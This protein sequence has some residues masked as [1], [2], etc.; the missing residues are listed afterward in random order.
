MLFGTP[1]VTLPTD[2]IKS[3]LVLG[4]YKQMEITNPPVAKNIKD[5]VDLAVHYANRDDIDKLKKIY[6]EAAEKKLFNTKKAGDEFNKILLDL[7]N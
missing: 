7:F 4:A 1:T 5:Y 6:R 2:H 3:R